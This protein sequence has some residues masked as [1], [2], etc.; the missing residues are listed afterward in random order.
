VH[1]LQAKTTSPK[2]SAPTSVTFNSDLQFGQR[3]PRISRTARRHPRN[4]PH[5]Q[6]GG[7]LSS[8][9][10]YGGVPRHAPG[11][12]HQREHAMQPNASTARP[13]FSARERIY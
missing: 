10:G 6:S 12:S 2:Q 7:A 8:K 11:G 1:T 3:K 13:S 5:S 4:Y 9:P